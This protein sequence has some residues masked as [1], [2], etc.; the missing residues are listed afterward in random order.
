MIESKGR[1]I[2]RSLSV[3]DMPFA[4]LMSQSALVECARCSWKHNNV[5]SNYAIQAS[6]G[7]WQRRILRRRARAHSLD[8]LRRRES[9]DHG[10][11]P[12]PDQMDGNDDRSELFSYPW[13]R[14]SKID[15][16]TTVN[17]PTLASY[18]PPDLVIALGCTEYDSRHGVSQEATLPYNDEASSS[19]P[20]SNRVRKH[21]RAPWRSIKISV[22]GN[23][24]TVEVS[25]T[26]APDSPQS[27]A[28]SVSAAAAAALKLL[29]SS[30][31][32]QPQKVDSGNVKPPE[33]TTGSGNNILTTRRDNSRTV[34]SSTSASSGKSSSERIQSRFKNS[35]LQQTQAQCSSSSSSS[36]DIRGSEREG[37]GVSDV[38]QEAVLKAALNHKVLERLCL[39]ATTLELWES[40]PGVVML[41][42]MQVQHRPITSH[43]V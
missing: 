19:S 18:L 30:T 29:Q 41:I 42:A 43:E 20:V 14:N 26:D 2:L 28:D 22:T 27:A 32:S 24:A 37:A 6:A 17:S 15:T 38:P 7:G 5:G 8:K 31:E 39:A 34:N 3:R 13:R 12:D 40:L 9:S 23:G 11:W 35:H 25:I 21:R 36:G 33:P 4:I 16:G 1:N 10:V